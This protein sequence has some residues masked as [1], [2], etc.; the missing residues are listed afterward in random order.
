MLNC[1]LLTV[2]GALIGSSG[3]ILSYIMC[4]AMNRSLGNVV[5][6]GYGTPAPTAAVAGGPVEKLVHV[7]TNADSVAEMLVNA[8]SVIIAPG[9]GLAVA[10]AQYP[11]AD[12]VARLRKQGVNVRFGIHPVAG[13]MPGQL[14]V[15]LA[16]AGVPYDVG[17]WL[18]VHAGEGTCSANALR[19]QYW[20]WTRSTRTSRIR[21]SRW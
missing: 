7:E 18:H 21:T 4:K 20:S 9:Y 17:A 15:L 10:R 1:D 16:E 5:L 2:V 3:G 6:G 14:N 13:R 11:V 12:M 8:K 19:S